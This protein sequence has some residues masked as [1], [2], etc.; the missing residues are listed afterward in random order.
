MSEY[1]T[2]T[3]ETAARTLNSIH[4]KAEDVRRTSRR[5]AQVANDAV[6]A[7]DEG[8]SPSDHGQWHYD[9]TVAVAALNGMI[10][11]ARATDGVTQELLQKAVQGRGLFFMV[12]AK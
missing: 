6:K 7:I 2:V 4:S 1:P 12:D 11:V 9:F 5:L 8:F 3:T 10:E